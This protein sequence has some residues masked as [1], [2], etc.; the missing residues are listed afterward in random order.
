[1][2]RALALGLA[3]A[4]AVLG[5]AATGA[6]AASAPIHIRA[7]SNRA[8]LVSAGNALVAITLPRRAQ[9]RRLKVT[10]NRRNVT[11]LFRHRSGLRFEGLVNRLR[12]GRNRLVA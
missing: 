11:G 5:I 12:L 4:L 1:M 10:L 3:I 2:P 6:Q 7:L 8:D 9:A